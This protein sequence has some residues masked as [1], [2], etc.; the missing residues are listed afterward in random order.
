[1]A[2]VLVFLASLGAVGAVGSFITHTVA[3]M[4]SLARIEPKP[5]LTSTVYAAD[6]SVLAE[7]HGHEHRVPV[8]LDQVPTY[9]RQAFIAVEDERFYSHFGIDLRGIARSVYVILTRRSLQGGSTITQQLA[10]NAFLTIEQTMERKL[11]EAIYAIQLERI[12]T[13]DEIL[14]MYLNQVPFGRGAYGVQAAAYAYFRKD[15]SDLTLAEAAF[16]AGLPWSPWTYDRD[17]DVVLRRQKVVLQQMAKV[18]YITEEQRQEAEAAALAVQPPPKDEVR[19]APHFLDY[20]LQYVLDKYGVQAVY[21]GGLRIYTTLDPR[22]QAGAEAAI[23]NVLDPV[24]PLVAGE[25]PLQA[26]SVILDPATGHIKAMVGGRTHEGRLGLNRVLSPRQPGSAIKPLVVYIPAIDLGFSPG[27]VVDDAPVAYPQHGGPPWEPQNY[28]GTFRGLVTLRT[29]LNRSINIVAIKLLE[30]IGPKTGI[31]Y[32]RQLG[33]TTLVADTRGGKTDQGLALALG[34]LTDGV[35]VMEM[36][37]AFGVLAN[38]GVRVEPVAVLRV[39]DK[40]GNEY[41]E[42]SPRP[43]IVLSEQTVYVL[44]NMLGTVITDGTGRAAAIG[45]PA[46]GKTGTT[47]DYRDAWFVG[48]TPDLVGAVWMGYDKGRTMADHKVTGGSYPARIWSTMMATAHE[49]LPV[50]EFPKLHRDQLVEVKICAR[51]G[52]LPGPNCPSSERVTEV[53][54]KGREPKQTCTTHV[55]AQVC[56]EHPGYLATEWCPSTVEKTFIRRPEPYVVGTN[57]KLPLDAHLELPEESCPF[58]GGP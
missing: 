42:A 5:S 48:Y 51:S 43:H 54:L 19:M 50:R 36:A 38:Q 46:A 52:Q 26:A 8:R 57:G 28:E 22:L 45:R 49:G 18:G 40:D 16:L 3:T 55:R 34:A 32:A 41:V 2:L 7:L 27:D 20:V 33:I 58:H 44:N 47:D 12:Y 9:L 21:T 10:R 6:G 14:E 53:Y 31:N 56:A 1:V 30:R 17:P 13:K 15:V 4:P 39:V 37:S 23:Q 11:R 24:F 29:A 25:T 35:T